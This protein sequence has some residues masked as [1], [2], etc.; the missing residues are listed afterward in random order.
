MPDVDADFGKAANFDAIDGENVGVKIESAQLAQQSA[1]FIA[2]DVNHRLP[3]CL[4]G[5]G[6]EAVADGGRDAI[7]SG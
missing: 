7:R 5:D 3:V 2:R 4:W 6:D 1:A